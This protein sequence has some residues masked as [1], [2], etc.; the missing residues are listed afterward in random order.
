M[1]NFLNGIVVTG[2]CVIIAY[3][4]NNPTMEGMGYTE[5]ERAEMDRIVLA[6]ALPVE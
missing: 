4:Y 1:N 2:F 6:W 5:Q 3:A